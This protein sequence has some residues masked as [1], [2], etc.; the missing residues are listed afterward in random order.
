MPKLKGLNLMSADYLT[1]YMP[2]PGYTCITVPVQLYTVLKAE[3]SKAGCSIPELIRRILGTSTP[4]K[5][6]S[7]SIRS[8]STN[9]GG[10]TQNLAPSYED[11]CR[12][13]DLNRRQSGLQPDALPG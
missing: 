12:G 6:T 9:G 13:P 3:A 5:S 2:K 11:K 10:K 8:T 4:V 1:I 7:T